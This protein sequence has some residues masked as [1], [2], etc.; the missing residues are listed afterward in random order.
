MPAYSLNPETIKAD[1]QRGGY[2]PADYSHKEAPGS[3]SLFHWHCGQRMRRVITFEK[4]NQGVRRIGCN[5]WICRVCKK[6]GYAFL[7]V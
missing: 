7:D 5:S 3:L 6:R 1:W 2:S 4:S